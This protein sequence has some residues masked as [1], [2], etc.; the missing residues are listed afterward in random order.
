MCLLRI[1]IIKDVKKKTEPAV[2]VDICTSPPSLQIPV[3]VLPQNRDRDLL[4]RT[5]LF[6]QI[7]DRAPCLG[8]RPVLSCQAPNR[9]SFLLTL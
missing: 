3:S 6:I 9:S 4:L 8:V 5:F 7:E 2:F 1:M